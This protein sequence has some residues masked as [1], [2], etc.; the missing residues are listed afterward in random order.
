MENEQ[1]NSP[2]CKGGCGFYGSSAFDGLCSK[3]FKDQLKRKQETIPR[4]TSSPP[5]MNDDKTT[6]TNRHILLPESATKR[7]TPPPLVVESA[8]QE[9]AE[10]SDNV[11]DEHTTVASALEFTTTDESQ[12][13]IEVDMD[14]SGASL[15]SASTSA[16]VLDKCREVYFILFFFYLVLSLIYFNINLL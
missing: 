4:F 8:V 11:R 10:N 5:R 2:M 12:K 14:T 3:C 6:T 16:I 1:Q 7:L 13:S 15:D 9:I